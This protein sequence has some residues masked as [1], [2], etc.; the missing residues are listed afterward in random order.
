MI[1]KEVGQESQHDSLLQIARLSIEVEYQTLQAL[2]QKIGYEFIEAIELIGQAAGRVIVTGVGKSALIG[3]K[4]VAT[5]NSTG[6]PSIFMHAADALH[7]DLGILQDGDVVLCL[8][9]SGETEELKRVIPVIR[10]MN[11]PII[12]VVANERSHL[13]RMAN[14]VIATPVA[15]EADPNNLAPTASTLAQLAVGDALA[16]CLIARN[17]FKPNDFAELHPG[18]TLGKRLHLSVADLCQHNEIASVTP[19]TSIRDVIIEI[20]S[21][22]LGATAV[23]EPDGTLVGIITDGD[24]R[25][26]LQNNTDTRLL[27]ASDIMT[28]DPKTIAGQ[29]LAASAITVMKRHNITQLLVLDDREYRG[30][31]HI[32]DLIKEGFI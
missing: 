31:I 7:G 23:V 19:D 27:T 28:S 17:G 22:R 6:T 3:K 1:S 20:S 14:V 4:L 30:I 29:A 26:M 21:K 11:C 5:F 2:S 24:L 18:G 10:K 12:A 15:R 8:S 9:K 25:R 16:A 32:H 13:A